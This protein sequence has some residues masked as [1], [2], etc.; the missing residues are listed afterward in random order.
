MEGETLTAE[1]I[2]VVLE[3]QLKNHSINATKTTLGELLPPKYSYKYV[4]FL[5]KIT[6]KH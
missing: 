2:N 1:G 3:C 5:L 4:G 6:N